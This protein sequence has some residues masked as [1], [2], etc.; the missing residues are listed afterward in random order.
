[1]P[2]DNKHIRARIRSILEKRYPTL[3]VAVRDIDEV[4]QNAEKDCYFAEAWIRLTVEEVQYEQW[5]H[6][7]V[8]VD[9]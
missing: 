3:R 7:F 8:H 1:M 6:E 9:G 2:D 4:G 5:M